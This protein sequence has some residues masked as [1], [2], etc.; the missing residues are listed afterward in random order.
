MLGEENPLRTVEA[1]GLE[2]QARRALDVFGDRA[3]E[4][5][6]EVDLSPLEHRCPRDV[7]GH[8]LEHQPFDARDL[9][10]VLLVGLGDQLDTRRERDKAVWTRANRR[11]LEAVVADLLDVPARDD[12]RS[13]R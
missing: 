6:A 5:L 9:A 8:G 4:N 12:P 11:L 2:H 7:V 1:D 10:P 13:A 3:P